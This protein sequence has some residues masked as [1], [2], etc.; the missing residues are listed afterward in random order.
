MLDTSLYPMIFKRKSFHLFRNLPDVPLTPEEL[1]DIYL[2]YKSFQAL[3]PNIRTEIS[4]VPND[5][6]S[7]RRGQEYCILLY[8]EHKD[9]YLANIGYLGQQ[10]DLYLVSKNIGT[11]WFGIG[12]TEEKQLNGLD[13]VIMIAIRK[14]HDDSKFRKNMFKSKRKTLEEIWHGKPLDGITEIVRFAPSACNT[15]PWLVERKENHLYIYRYKMP[16]RRGIMPVK[17]VTYYNQIDIG[18]FLY[19]LNLCLDNKQILYIVQYHIDHGTDDERILLAEYD[20]KLGGDM[21]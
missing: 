20:L 21:S 10:L 16:G 8:S 7:C 5:C 1:D 12:R 13:Y 9:N 4:I 2:A 18:I 6:C 3:D 14:I 19:F 11:L 17:L 15:Q